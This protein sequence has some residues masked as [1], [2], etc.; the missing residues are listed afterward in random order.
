M[1][2]GRIKLFHVEPTTEDNPPVLKGKIEY[3][4]GSEDEVTL[5]SNKHPRVT[6]GEYFTGQIYTK[7]REV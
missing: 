3:A 4:D 6:G 5:W 1:V 2:V 7:D